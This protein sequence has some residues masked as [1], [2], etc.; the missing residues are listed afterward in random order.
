[1]I[2]YNK[3]PALTHKIHLPDPLFFFSAPHVPISLRI[4]DRQLQ[5]K[6]T[7]APIRVLHRQFS[8]MQ[9]NQFY[10]D[11]QPQPIMRFVISGL[12]RAV[13]PVKDSFFIFF[14]NAAAMVLR[15]SRPTG[16]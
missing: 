1:M 3:M 4:P 5:H 16:Q 6:R 11:A 12:I 10:G 7:S 15:A 14:R 2:L 9:L 13:K 8:V